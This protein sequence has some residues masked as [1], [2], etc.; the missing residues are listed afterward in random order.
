MEI[1]LIPKKQKERALPRFASFRGPKIKPN[2]WSKLGIILLVLTIVASGGLFIWK[3]SL[4]KEKASL[5]EEFKNTVLNRDASLE[6]ELAGLDTL[7]NSFVSVFKNQRNWSGLFGVIEKRT[8]QSVTFTS[9]NG[10][11]QTGTFT[12]GGLAP[13]FNALAQQA[14]FLEEDD[15]IKRV[16]ISNI[17]VNK[18][19]RITFNLSVTFDKKLLNK[20]PA[21]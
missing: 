12:L 15:N 9:F 13:D 2:L 7:I 4:A 17:S 10:S 20:P 18:E 19:G 6:S 21:G 3:G 14:K 5:Q 1:S 11:S 16:E 8:V